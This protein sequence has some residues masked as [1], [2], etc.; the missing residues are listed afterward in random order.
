M[1]QDANQSQEQMIKTYRPGGWKIAPWHRTA[2]YRFKQDAKKLANDGWIVF[3]VQADSGV[4]TDRIT[5]VYMR[6]V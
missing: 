6:S 4:I 1:T 3:Q 5:V 2:T